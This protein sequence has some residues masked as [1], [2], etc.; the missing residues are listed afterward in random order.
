MFIPWHTSLQE[1]IVTH[2]KF[3]VW[4]PCGTPVEPLGHSPTMG[5]TMAPP[6]VRPCMRN[7]LLLGRKPQAQRPKNTGHFGCHNDT[8]SLASPPKVMS[9]RRMFDPTG[10]MFWEAVEVDFIR[11]WNN[12]RFCIEHLLINR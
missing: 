11:W 1:V 3:T 12:G 7:W 6:A 5:S 9:P 8:M 10:E 2:C 4:N